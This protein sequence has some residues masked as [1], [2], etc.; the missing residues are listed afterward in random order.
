MK[1]RRC[2][3]KGLLSLEA[4]IAVT[5][6]IFLMLFMYSFFVVFEARNE[7]AHVLL[8]TANSMALDSYE[9]SK[10]GDSDT[11]GQLF[12]NIYG[13]ITNTNNSFTDYRQWHK[14][15][16]ETDENGNIT[17]STEFSDVL[18][19]RFLSYL[20]GGDISRAEEILKRFHIEHGVAGLDFSGSYV[21]D[22]KL[23]LSVSYT[24]EYEFNMF[25]LGILEMEQSACS[26]IWE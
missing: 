25:G 26:K 1:R 14:G 16:T 5:I 4:C 12:Y 9:N 11:A 13:Q 19:N 15:S 6:F 17:L 8:S 18:K 20:T 7:M 22:G 21:A 24:L 10:L 3:E 23:F 2:G